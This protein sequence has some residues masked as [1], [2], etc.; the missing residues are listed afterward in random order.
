M[1]ARPCSNMLLDKSPLFAVEFERLEESLMLV[2][3]PPA[4][5]ELC[6]AILIGPIVR[7]AL[8]FA[9]R[10]LLQAHALVPMEPFLALFLLAPRSSSLSLLSGRAQNA[11]LVGVP[12]LLCF[13]FLLVTH[14]LSL[15]ELGLLVGGRH[16]AL[17]LHL[18]CQVEVHGQ[19]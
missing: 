2:F 5:F 14:E 16:D 1:G 9:L 3:G 4:C 10:E 19:L 11:L 13:S 7:L 15:E 18:V 6:L 17:N 12:L 8:G